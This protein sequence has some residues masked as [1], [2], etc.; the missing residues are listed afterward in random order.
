MTKLAHEFPFKVKKNETLNRDNSL[1]SRL[2]HS[3]KK[4][5]TV[6]DTVSLLKF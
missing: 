1:T 5:D 6:W 3:K 2:Q 4:E